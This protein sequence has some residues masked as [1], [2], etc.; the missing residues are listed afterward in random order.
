MSAKK[1]VIEDIF[2]FDEVKHVYTLNGKRMYGVTSVLGVIAKGG[3]TWWASKMACETLGRMHHKDAKDKYI[4]NSERVSCAQDK[5]DEIKEMEAAEY[6]KLLDEAYKK[7][8]EKKNDAADKGKDVHSICEEIIN[9]A[10][11]EN[12]G[13]ISTLVDIHTDILGAGNAQ[14][15]HFVNWAVKENV[16]F[17]ASEKKAYSSVMWVAGTFDFTAIIHSKKMMGDIKTY[18]AIHDRTPFLQCGGYVIM[19]EEKGNYYDG[20]VIVRMGKD[21]SFEVMYSYDLEGDK[22]GFLFALGLYKCLDS[23][24]KPETVV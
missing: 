14:V 5:L 19:E 3:L 17:I 24:Q 16:Q 10:I 1:K 23:W 12:G 13:F 22:A 9:K 15:Q 11:A 6:L 7:H 18:S 21:G 2:E 20:S 8:N 4:A